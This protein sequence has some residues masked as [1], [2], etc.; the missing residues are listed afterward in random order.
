MEKQKFK[1]ARSK[2][3]AGS[4]TVEFTNE[5]PLDELDVALAK[6]SMTAAATVTPR[7][8]DGERSGGESTWE[9]SLRLRVDARSHSIIFY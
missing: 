8:I 3:P 5:E 2:A 4:Y 9:N 7:V 6:A 1:K